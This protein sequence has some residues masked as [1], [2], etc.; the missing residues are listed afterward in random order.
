LSNGSHTVT[1]TVR[2]AAGNTGS[3]SVSVTVRN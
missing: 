1:A 2:D 3:S